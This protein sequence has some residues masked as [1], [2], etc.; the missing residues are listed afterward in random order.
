MKRATK[1]KNMPMKAYYN[2][3]YVD[4]MANKFIENHEKYGEKQAVIRLDAHLTTKEV[5]DIA[6]FIKKLKEAN[7][8]ITPNIA[9]MLI[10]HNPQAVVDIPNPSRKLY[11]KAILAKPAIIAII[12][13]DSFLCKLA[14]NR[15]ITT[16]PVINEKF[17][18][19]DHCL[20]YN[21]REK[22]LRTVLGKIKEARQPKIETLSELPAFGI[23]MEFMT[24]KPIFE[25]YLLLKKY[26][27]ISIGSEKNEGSGW[28][29]TQEDTKR[30]TLSVFEVSS[31]RLQPDNTLDIKGL[32]Q[33][34]MLLEI[35][36]KFSHVATN[37]DCC[38]LHVHINMQENYEEVIKHTSN[39]MYLQPALDK[40][41]VSNRRYNHF[42][43][44]I[45][46]TVLDDLKNS[47]EKIY[48]ELEN[49]FY[50]INPYSY[51]CHGTLEFRQHE[52]V[53]K[54][55]SIVHWLSIIQSLIT[56]PE[57]KN[58]YILFLDDLYNI[59][60]VSKETQEHYTNKYI[61]GK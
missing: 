42:C 47:S 58:N 10:N 2:K 32:Y 8:T 44:P 52:S 53:F 34:C 29:L 37:P 17:K 23:E 61:K 60:N 41:F 12:P 3:L 35:L 16:Y 9:E 31:K 15:D 50:S 40:L 21:K 1:R 24:N 59:L 28:M 6:P 36:Q 19:Y 13:Q 46:D 22:E 48:K 4:E 11:I 55:M 43:M 30:S 45:T 51:F 7:I 56:L 38:G 18:T 33:A 57:R 39:Y 5:Y 25:V 14:M 49:R 20:I 27:N 54:F 26:I